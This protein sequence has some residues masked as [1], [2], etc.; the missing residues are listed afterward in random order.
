MEDYQAT[1]QVVKEFTNVIHIWME[2]HYMR[3][4]TAIQPIFK[5]AGCPAKA[6]GNGNPMAIYLP[7]NWRISSG[8]GAVRCPACHV[9]FE[10]MREPGK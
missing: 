8:D 7:D 5:C 6:N 2:K 10:A 1:P 3:G 4:A 9:L